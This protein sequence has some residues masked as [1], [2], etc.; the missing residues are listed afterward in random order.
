MFKIYKSKIF[1]PGFMS[2]GTKIRL[3]MFRTSSPVSLVSG[4]GLIPSMQGDPVSWQMKEVV[5]DLQGMQ[6]E[7]SKQITMIMMDKILS[8]SGEHWWEALD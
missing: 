1:S 8:L 2:S 6:V 4:A 5:I 7:P 3:L